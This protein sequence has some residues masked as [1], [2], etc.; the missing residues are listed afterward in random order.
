MF[1]CTNLTTAGTVSTHDFCLF[2]CLLLILSG[3]YKKNLRTK[4]F[5]RCMTQVF[6]RTVP[7]SSLSS[8]TCVAAVAPNLIIYL[9]Q[10]LSKISKNK[11]CI[12]AKI[13]YSKYSKYSTS[14]YIVFDV[15]E[16]PHDATR[17]YYYLL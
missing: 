13:R 2:S 11:R 5:H 14:L 8:T 6:S 12:G 16:N 17:N 4:H 9:K 15:I 1:A 7:L 3:I 10:S